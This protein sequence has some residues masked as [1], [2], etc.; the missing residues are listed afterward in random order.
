MVSDN[1]VN[2][3]PKEVDTV[4]FVS[5]RPIINHLY[6]VQVVPSRSADYP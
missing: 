4:L 1:Y 2:Q 6:R 3:G 5:T